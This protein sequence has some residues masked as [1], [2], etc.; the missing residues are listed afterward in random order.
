[1]PHGAWMH[2]VLTPLR[3]KN[4]KTGPALGLAGAQFDVSEA[5][6]LRHA[7]FSG[8]MRGGSQ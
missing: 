8:R 2:K 5:P 1:V 6:K 7:A 4:E 3:P